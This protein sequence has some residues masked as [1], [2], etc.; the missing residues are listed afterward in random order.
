MILAGIIL[1]IELGL[2]VTLGPPIR[3]RVDRTVGQ[4]RSSTRDGAEDDTTGDETTGETASE[5]A[6]AGRDDTAVEGES[7]DQQ[8]KETG[9]TSEDGVLDISGDTGAPLSIAGVHKIVPGDNLFH[10]SFRYW[11][12]GRLWPFLYYSNRGLLGD[13]DLLEVGSA[14][15]V[16][17]MTENPVS[18]ARTREG[19]AANAHISAYDAY[20][21]A[22]ESMVAAGVRTRDSTLVNRGRTKVE[23]A[24]WVLY[25]AGWFVP[26]FP[27]PYADQIREED[28]LILDSYQKRFGPPFGDRETS[29]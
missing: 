4:D 29:R 10:L 5:G 6:P 2:L 3:T 19:V 25:A 24:R 1:L 7:L 22:G 17:D 16:P 27:G 18:F 28:L 13:P 21:V 14:L 11:D 9:E 20:R 26:T 12:D 15:D 23:K 8:P